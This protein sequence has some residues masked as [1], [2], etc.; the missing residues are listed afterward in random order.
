MVISAREAVTLVAAA[1]NAA[2][3]ASAIVLN[4]AR[5]TACS[6]KAVYP[7]APTGLANPVWR[8]IT[9]LARPIGAFRLT[10]FPPRVSTRTAG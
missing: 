10:L 4:V 1:A 2:K 3:A 9:G 7:T 6:Q 8:P 5:I